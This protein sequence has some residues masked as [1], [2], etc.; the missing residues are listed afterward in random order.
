MRAQ[1]S[2]T[3]GLNVF[4]TISRL[5]TRLGL[6]AREPFMRQQTRLRVQS[7]IR[8]LVSHYTLERVDPGPAFKRAEKH[9][10]R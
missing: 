10:S 9:E 4:H 8:E 3:G 2:V 5:R 1:I 6:A 7:R